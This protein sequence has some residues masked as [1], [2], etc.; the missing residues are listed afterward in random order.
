MNRFGKHPVCLRLYHFGFQTC[1]YFK[2][3]ESDNFTGA[4]DSGR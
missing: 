2:G 1:Y 4:G 3:L